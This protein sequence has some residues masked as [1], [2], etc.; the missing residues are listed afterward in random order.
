M[1]LR[2]VCGCGIVAWLVLALAMRAAA[3]GAPGESPR[4]L[5]ASAETCDE[6]AVR[7]NEA[8]TRRLS[9]GSSAESVSAKRSR[10]VRW[11][12]NVLRDCQTIGS[13]IH[14]DLLD[15]ADP[16]VVTV[17]RSY[18]TPH[19]S[20]V[21][22]G[23][24]ATHP[25]SSIILV[26]RGPVL[27]GDVRLP[28]SS[29]LRIASAGDS[30]PGL[31]VISERESLD[32]SWCG[33][34]EAAVAGGCG[35][36]VPVGLPV[37]PIAPSIDILVL[38]TPASRAAAGGVVSIEAQIE[39]HIA[40]TN[41][42]YANSE[43]SFADLCLVRMAE[44]GY[45]ET[46][47]EC[48]VHDLFGNDIPVKNDV[49]HDTECLLD[50]HGAD[51]VAL[52]VL[53]DPD[54]DLYGAAIGMPD[55]GG[56]PPFLG[57]QDAVYFATD[58]DKEVVFAHEAGHCMG[59]GHN[60]D[61]GFFFESKAHGFTVG[62]IEY[63]TIMWAG[64]CDG[65]ENPVSIQHFS[66]PSVDYLGEPTGT[67]SANNA[68]TLE[69]LMPHVANYEDRKPEWYA[70][71][72]SNPSSQQTFGRE[73][74][75]DGRW[76]AVAQP[77]YWIDEVGPVGV[78]RMY[79]KD[80]DFIFGCTWGDRA[81][82]PPSEDWGHIQQAGTAVDTDGDR[83][84]FSAVGA[85]QADDGVVYIYRYDAGA[86]GFIMEARLTDPASTFPN[87]RF[88]YQVA[89]EGDVA[90]AT[91]PWQTG[92]SASVF[93][94]QPGGIWAF[95]QSLP[96]AEPYAGDYPIDV[97]SGQIAMTV[98]EYDNQRGAALYRFDD[99]TSVWV[100]DQLVLR[101]YGQA[102][103]NDYRA[104]GVAMS[105]E[106]LVVSR[107]YR[108][109]Y[110][111][112]FVGVQAGVDIYRFD[113]MGP[114]GAQ[115]VFHSAFDINEIAPGGVWW[116]LLDVD[117]SANVIAVGD[118]GA[119]IPEQRGAVHV[120]EYSY[121]T[122]TWSWTESF[123]GPP[124][125]YGRFGWRSDAHHSYV[126]GAN[127]GGTGVPAEDEFVAMYFHTPGRP[128]GTPE[129]T[130]EIVEQPASMAVLQ[131]APAVFHVAASEQDSGPYAYRWRRNGVD[132]VE[133]ASPPG[134]Q[135]ALALGVAT[136][137]LTITSVDPGATGLYECWVT[138]PGCI[139]ASNPAAL[140]I[141][142]PPCPPDVSG[143]GI[144]DFEDILSVL[145][146]WGYCPGCAADVDG[147]TQVGFAD[148]L[149]LLAA[150]GPCP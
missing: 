18:V 39:L 5:F 25:G 72:F 50:H 11:D 12:A 136:D 145:F 113:A 24:D 133:G 106:W 129:C 20:V 107:G 44:V 36:S 73:L 76:L 91:S 90:V 86:D 101:S 119:G 1:K 74:S 95:E 93:R 102:F 146:L 33:T 7:S 138:T 71:S 64:Y 62:S 118:P 40:W 137:T 141:Y 37:L 98:G 56:S 55:V 15:E 14:L 92:T 43:V 114:Q 128:I 70:E 61:A 46:T 47:V 41:Q 67:A 139:R 131:F 84:I 8:L 99:E 57:N 82:L 121:A 16:V 26:R 13:K 97:V 116:A 48:A 149:A 9:S 23:R 30:F 75:C 65:C 117:V 34:A 142:V 80:T 88:G 115:W 35:G 134:S 144:V 126:I 42:A 109:A 28:E 66:S 38:Y 54:D 81:I 148:L 79:F 51:L 127:S 49:I 103:F 77:W 89:I 53:R 140:T 29:G 32:G 135:S 112:P 150:W 19:G 143:N 111:E 87:W 85:S 78:I 2:H 31:S 132:L 83:V 96:I 6:V 68:G 58:W 110:P 10:L 21:W 63:H 120:L 69:I 4:R 108:R 60:D 104:R 130:L 17:D 123:E 52:L 22:H 100:L 147:D 27:V 94:R 122:D 105:G 59:A 45:E 125:E 3:S 124:V